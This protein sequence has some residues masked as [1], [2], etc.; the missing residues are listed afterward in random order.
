[1]TT[2]KVLMAMTSNIATI[3]KMI[4]IPLNAVL[5]IHAGFASNPAMLTGFARKRQPKKTTAISVK[6]K[7]MKTCLNVQL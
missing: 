6:M 1:M 5:Q 2:R 3:A 4:R 7:G